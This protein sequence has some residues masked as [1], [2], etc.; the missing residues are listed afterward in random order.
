[1]PRLGLLAIPF[2]F[3]LLGGGGAA[4]ASPPQVDDQPMWR[5]WPVWPLHRQHPIRGGFMDPRGSNQKPIFHN[6]IDI[7]VRDGRPERGHPYDRTHRVYAVEP[8]TVSTAPN[9]DDLACHYRSVR[10]GS[11][12]YGHTDPVG[13]V[14]P[15][16]H[17]DAGEQIGW[18]CRT[19]Y[20]VHLAHATT[21]GGRQVWDN[22]LKTGVLRPYVDTAPPAVHAIR[23]M[24]VAAPVTWFSWGGAINSRMDV[25]PLDRS[26][27]QGTVSVDASV[28]DRQSF[29]G[30]LAQFPV[31]VAD[32]VPYSVRVSVTREDDGLRV[33]SGNPFRADS[34]PT[35]PG[36]N[37][38]VFA[39]GTSENL[40]TWYCIDLRMTS[41]CA[42]TY[43]F[44]LFRGGWDTTTVP[45]GAYRVCVDAYDV[46][47]NH[48][49]ACVRATVAN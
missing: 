1:M 33:A 28:S 43:W 17:V 16:Q 48:A 35:D 14:Q 38:T 7:S 45:N 12:V 6:G 41:G 21:I 40:P 20:H 30:W 32:Q 9:V 2:A 24:P 27:L 22:P 4:G 42:G 31:L 37:G 13:T 26:H 39:G 8:G 25:A 36:L 23:F 11:F 46:V 10:V 44:H 34:L 5:G 18:T 29:S 3:L 47:L 19:L 15:G 49:R